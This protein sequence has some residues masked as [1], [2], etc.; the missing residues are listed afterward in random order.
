MTR[1]LLA[2]L[3]LAI[4]LAIPLATAGDEPDPCATLDELSAAIHTARLTAWGSYKAAV[5]AR[6]VAGPAVDD[7]TLTEFQAGRVVDRILEAREILTR[8]QRTLACSPLA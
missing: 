5:E 4:P 1:Q 8:L 2:V 6:Q 7:L 3:V